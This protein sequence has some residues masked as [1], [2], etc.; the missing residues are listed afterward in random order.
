MKKVYIDADSILYRAA[1]LSTVDSDLRKA[2]SIQLEDAEDI[3]LPLANGNNQLEEASSIFH[4]MVSDIMAH[5]EEA[6]SD[7]DKVPNLVVTVKPSL[8]DVEP[9]FRYALMEGIEGVKGYK[10]NRK[11]METPEGLND[12]YSY[13]HALDNTICIEGV[14]ADDVVVYYGRQGHI[15]CA[16]DKDVLGSLEEAFNYNKMEWVAN[17][18]ADIVRFPYY[19]TLTG[20]PGDGL[21]GAVRVGAV[22]ASKALEGTESEA[23]MWN[24]VLE[25]YD[26]KGQTKE[27]ALATMRCV[28]MDQWSPEK[29]LSLWKYQ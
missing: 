7:I 6:E 14:E 16:L 17:E 3:D 12:L 19:Q 20:D 13:V 11:D 24:A 22:G 8:Y 28:R 9:N 5:I 25:V 29:G 26:S 23:D 15:V 2:E 4:S 18:P 27:E 1:H 10:E 21:R